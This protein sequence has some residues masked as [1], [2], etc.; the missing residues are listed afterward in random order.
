IGAGKNAGADLSIAGHTHDNRMRLYKTGDNT[1]SVAYKLVT[2][3]GVSPTEKYYAASVPRTQAAH[4]IVM[5]MPGDF[6]EQA[7]PVTYLREQGRE[8]LRRTVEQEMKKKRK[9]KKKR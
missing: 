1:W 2:L 6:S 5:P 9:R 7:I 3:Q 4:K 8:S